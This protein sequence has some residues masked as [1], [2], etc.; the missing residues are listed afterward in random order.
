MRIIFCCSLSCILV[1][2]GSSFKIRQSESG[3]VQLRTYFF[4]STQTQT[5]TDTAKVWYYDSTTIEELHIIN[6]VT[7]AN[8]ITVVTYPVFL[9]RYIDFRAKAW[10]TYLTFSDTARI[11]NMGILPD[12]GF[13]NYGWNFF[14]KTAREIEGTPQPLSDTVTEGQSFKR[15]RFKT[16]RSDPDVVTIAYLRCDGV[17]LLLFSLEKAYSRQKNCIMTKRFG[18]LEGKTQPFVAKHVDF[19]RDSLT[20]QE[21]KVFEAWKKNMLSNPIK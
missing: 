21:M 6:S 19:V 12:S 4:D 1:A 10:Y 11:V 14:P 9:H 13:T 18:Y 20:Q 16:K 7:D 3:L 2:C 5:F 15:I 8:G 17:G